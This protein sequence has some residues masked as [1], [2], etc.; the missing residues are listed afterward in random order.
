MLWDNA[1]QEEAALGFATPP[2]THW[3]W[4]DTALA[5][6]PRLPLPSKEAP[7]LIFLQAKDGTSKSPISPAQCQ[8]RDCEDVS[9]VIYDPAGMLHECTTAW[10]KG[11]TLCGQR[12]VQ[13]LPSFPTF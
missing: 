12:E 8:F 13:F 7:S 5:H 4:Q 9:E 6:F 1:G 10:S 3:C 2:S 11:D